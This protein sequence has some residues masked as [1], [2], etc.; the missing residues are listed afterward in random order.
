M[1][2]LVPNKDK[3][4]QLSTVH[5]ENFL[6]VVSQIGYFDSNKLR[7]YIANFD[8]KAVTDSRLL[9]I[10]FAGKGKM[11]SLEGDFKSADTHFK[12]AMKLARQQNSYLDNPLNDESYAY[13]LYELGLFQ[14]LINEMS[15]SE[16]SFRESILFR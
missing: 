13:V 4:T 3:K 5:H 11:Y 10:I 6:E 12:Y 1:I 14:I 2:L 8:P 16:N 7:P 15:D 9:P